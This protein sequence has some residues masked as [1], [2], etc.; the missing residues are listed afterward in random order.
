MKLSRAH[1]VVA[2]EDAHRAMPCNLHGGSLVHARVRQVPNSGATKIMRGET[3]V[4]IPLR[5]RLLSDSDFN[6]PLDPRTHTNSHFSAV[7]GREPKMLIG[8]LCSKVRRLSIP[9]SWAAKLPA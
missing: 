7:K 4:L 9:P 1:N 5:P 2:Q 8:S 6:T 3:F